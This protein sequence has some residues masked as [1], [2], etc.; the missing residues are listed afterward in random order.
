MQPSPRYRLAIYAYNHSV[1]D[2]L[3][4][5][6]PITE[7]VKL[8]IS[9]M[10]P[11]GRTDTA[12]AFEQAEQLLISERGNLRSCP[13]PLVCHLTDGKYSADD[14]LPIVERIQ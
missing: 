13:A 3:D 14:P 4:G 8:G 7:V 12:A 2:L 6:R 11:S 1:H 10:K 5:P 9:P